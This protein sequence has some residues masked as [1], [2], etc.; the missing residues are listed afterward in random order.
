ME[1][2][3]S[4]GPGAPQ[5][6]RRTGTY[7][8]PIGK[9]C[10]SDSTSFLINIHRY[11]RHLLTEAGRLS[12]RRI[13][14]LVIPDVPNRGNYPTETS[15]N[16]GDLYRAILVDAEVTELVSAFRIY[17]VEAVG[18]AGSLKYRFRRLSTQDMV[19]SSSHKGRCNRRAK[20]TM[21]GS[22]LLHRGHIAYL[23]SYTQCGKSLE[24]ARRDY[25]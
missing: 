7:W 17:F 25:H 6:R 24:A 16:D 5:P 23:K 14:A 13:L 8:I 1:T 22:R 9:P 10:P 15:A 3:N 2:E 19:R 20:G 11:V 12:A 4:S 18:G 21:R